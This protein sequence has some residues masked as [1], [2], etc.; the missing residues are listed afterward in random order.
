[1]AD[2]DRLC[3]IRVCFNGGLFNSPVL[4]PRLLRNKCLVKY[5]DIAS[6]GRRTNERL[7]KGAGRCT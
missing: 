7:Q 1:M 5:S 4:K 3:Q 2:L 6:P